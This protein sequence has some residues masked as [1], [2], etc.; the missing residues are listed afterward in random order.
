M[1]LAEKLRRATIFL[2]LLFFVSAI[3]SYAPTGPTLYYVSPTNDSSII[4][5]KNIA[6]CCVV[7]NSSKGTRK[8]SD[9]IQSRYCKKNE[10]NKNTVAKVVKK[11]LR[12]GA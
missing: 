6:R 4:S 7:C 8:L 9:W 10:I 12:A 2:G 1:R 3:R 11:A 5:R